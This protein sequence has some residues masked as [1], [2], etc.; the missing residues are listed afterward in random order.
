MK[1]YLFLLMQLKNLQFKKNEMKSYFTYFIYYITF[2]GFQ[3]KL[4]AQESVVIL[5]N[6]F[7]KVEPGEFS[8]FID[9]S[10]ALIKE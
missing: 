5:A 8:L 10:R 7:I 2:I 4:V 6:Q 3:S 1:I 9:F